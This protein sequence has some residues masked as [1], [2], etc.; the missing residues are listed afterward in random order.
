MQFEYLRV[1]KRFAS[2]VTQPPLHTQCL[3]FKL[4]H[5]Q[6]V[7]ASSNRFSTIAEN[8]TLTL[9]R[10]PN[11]LQ[12]LTHEPGIRVPFTDITCLILFSPKLAGVPSPPPSPCIP[13]A[14][15][16]HSTCCYSSHSED[17]LASLQVITTCGEMFVCY[18]FLC[19]FTTSSFQTLTIS[20]RILLTASLGT[21]HIRSMYTPLVS[22]SDIRLSSLWTVPSGI[23]VL[24]SLL[25]RPALS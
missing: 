18:R 24:S 9:Q 5:T 11:A 25:A 3:L 12:K 17:I 13:C 7:R 20:P 1:K 15:F 6:R 10:I 23:P 21:L 4:V 2:Y 14:G 19:V 16:G 22:T 8:T